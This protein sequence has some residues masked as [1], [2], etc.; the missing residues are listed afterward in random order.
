MARSYLIA[1]LALVA[2]FAAPAF[3]RDADVERMQ[4]S[5]KLN[6]IQQQQFD[7]AMA[8]TQRAMLAIGMGALQFKSRLGMELL[9]ERPDMSSLATAQDELVEMSKPHVRAAK[10]EWLRFYAM[11][12]D[13]QVG[14]ARGYMDEKLRKLDRLAEH[15][16]REFSGSSTRPARPRRNEPPTETW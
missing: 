9:K 4:R 13:E 16:I 12:D 7:V 2:A 11:L 5:L 3:A 10:D 1:V 8:A 15:L 6:P 14:A